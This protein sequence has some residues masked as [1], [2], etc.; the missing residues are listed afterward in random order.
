MCMNSCAFFLHVLKM[1][2]EPNR[3]AGLVV[4][5]DIMLP[6]RL[7]FC[8]ETAG[9]YSCLTGNNQCY[10]LSRKCDGIRDC[11][12]GTDESNCRLIYQ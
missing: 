1:T 12:D 10:H 4:F 11:A 2:L 7:E 3:Y 9:F 6:R 8:N 5:S